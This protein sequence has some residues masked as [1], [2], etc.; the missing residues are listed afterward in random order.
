MASCCSSTESEKDDNINPPT[1]QY[2]RRPGARRKELGEDL[3]YL[4]SVETLAETFPLS[5][6]HGACGHGFSARVS[7]HAGGHAGH[8]HGTTDNIAP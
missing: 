3:D 1:R 4:V 6:G 8:V 7:A 5:L 2:K